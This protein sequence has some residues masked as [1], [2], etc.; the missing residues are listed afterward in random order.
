MLLIELVEANHRPFD[1]NVVT[2]VVS[3]CLLINK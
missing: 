1:S 3:E 2:F